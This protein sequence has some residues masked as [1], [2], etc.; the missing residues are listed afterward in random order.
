MH[1]TSELPKF[2]RPTF[3]VGHNVWPNSPATRYG[4]PLYISP[5]DEPRVLL[6][7]P[8]STQLARAAAAV[9][10]VTVNSNRRKVRAL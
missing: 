7:P 1:K 10:A 6:L 3:R 8:L 5:P 4:L 9:A 2:T